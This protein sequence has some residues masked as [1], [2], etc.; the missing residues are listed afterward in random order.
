MP[1]NNA[2]PNP[3]NTEPSSATINDTEESEN[4]AAAGETPSAVIP[5]IETND[6][7]P[8]DGASTEDNPTIDKPES[9]N[10]S[11]DNQQTKDVPLDKKE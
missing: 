7:D 4:E 1:T 5:A 2:S 9:A 8:I 10:L 3:I 11:D 6:S